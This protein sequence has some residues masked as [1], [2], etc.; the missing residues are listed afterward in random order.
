MSDALTAGRRSQPFAMTPHWVIFSGVSAPAQALYTSLLAHVHSDREDGL[1]WP[2]MN[3]LA[4]ILG[5]RHR[6]SI[7][8]FIKELVALGAVEVTVQK[9]ARGRRNI[10]T[11]HETP[12]D[13][14]RGPVSRADFY[15]RRRAAALPAGGAVPGA[16]AAPLPRKPCIVAG[17]RGS[18]AHGCDG[19]H[20]EAYQNKKKLNEKNKQ[21]FRHADARRD[22]LRELRETDPD[23]FIEA[24]EQYVDEQADYTFRTDGIVQSMVMR[25][26][27]QDTDLIINTALKDARKRDET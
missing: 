18:H 8:K 11:V 9:W 21:I 26:P 1:V 15:T 22:E 12:P 19:S 4:Q 25:E 13:G 3:V 16:G 10:Y 17:H 6:Q 2:G 20:A 27:Y 7:A 14:Y 24:V 5:Y 23:L